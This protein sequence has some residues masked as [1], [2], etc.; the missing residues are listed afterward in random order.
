MYNVRDTT[1]QHFC[2]D[3][4]PTYITYCILDDYD[5]YLAT[6]TEMKRLPPMFGGT[7]LY[8][9]SVRALLV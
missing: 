8:P 4:I 9:R 1:F 5:I 7:L 6:T 3:F 2:A